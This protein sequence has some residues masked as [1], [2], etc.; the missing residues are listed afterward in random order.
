M[1]ELTHTLYVS[2]MHCAACEHLITD[3][4]TEAGEK[5]VSVSRVREEVTLARTGNESVG[6]LIERVNPLLAPHG[7]ALHTERPVRA[8]VASEWLI[9]LPI[10]ALFVMGFFLLDRLGLTSLIGGTEATL[11][12]ALLIGLIASVSTCLAVVGTLV[13]SVSATYAHEGKGMRPQLYFHIGRLVGFFLL[14]GLLG[15]VGEA[16]QLSLVASAILGAVVS[17][18]ML[19][20]GIQLLD[21][22]KRVGV[23]TLPKKISSALFGSASKVGPLAPVAIGALTFFLPCGFTQSMQ[24]VALSTQSALQG[25]LTMLVFALGTLPVLALLSFGSLDLGKSRFKGVFFKSAGTLVIL[26]ALFNI[27]NALLTLGIIQSFIRF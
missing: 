26:F 18:V 15:L 21:I 16:V 22:T 19:L 14:G 2:G 4:L 13:L 5:D 27:H 10:V 17:V 12:T 6:A 8:A 20:L 1:T 9:A 23:P 7:Y 25:G 11:G 24:L 3:I